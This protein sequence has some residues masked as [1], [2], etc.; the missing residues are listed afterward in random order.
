MGALA[1]WHV[2]G[3]L[4]WEIV[5]FG[6]SRVQ[7]TH[8]G[9][10]GMPGGVGGGCRAYIQ[11]QTNQFFSQLGNWCQVGMLG[12]DFSLRLIGLGFLQLKRCESLVTLY[13]HLI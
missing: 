2:G 9:C 7:L 6:G 4:G 11:S 3:D 12:L 13:L 1:V 8:L 5:Y 10:F